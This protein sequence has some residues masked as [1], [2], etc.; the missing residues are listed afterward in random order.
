MGI[1]AVKVYEMWTEKKF[2]IKQSHS[3]LRGLSIKFKI[4]SMGPWQGERTCSMGSELLFDTIFI[5]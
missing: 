5:K 2:E 1:I 3:M 4:L